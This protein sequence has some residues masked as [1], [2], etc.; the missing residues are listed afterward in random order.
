MHMSGNNSSTDIHTPSK[1]HY[2]Y[3]SPQHQK[4][5]ATMASILGRGSTVM[6]RGSVQTK[7][8]IPRVGD[9]RVPRLQQL[10]HAPPKRT[11]A[12]KAA[13]SRPEAQHQNS[14]LPLYALAAAVS[15]VPFYYIFHS[16][17]SFGS[18]KTKIQQARREKGTEYEFRDPRDSPIKTLEQQKKAE[19]NKTK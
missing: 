17:K 3:T 14:R 11:Y 7:K 6:M 15:F 12:E 16:N 1:H 8:Q 4:H 2:I 13:P 10:Q 18:E 9:L 5:L 19:E